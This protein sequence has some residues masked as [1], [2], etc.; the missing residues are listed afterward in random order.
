MTAEPQVAV[1]A[2]AARDD[3]VL[4]VR[5]GRSWSLPG[6]LVRMGEDLREAVV[7]EVLD[8][9][10]LEVVVVEFAGWWERIE[11]DAAPPVHVVALAFGVDQ[12]DAA[13]VPAPGTGVAELNWTPLASL[14]EVP[15]AA[16]VAELLTDRGLL[17]PD[18]G[19]ELHR[20]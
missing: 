13:Q 16:G 5:Q 8:A 18:P 19:I 4:L 10:G 15:L 11:P 1:A 14:A 20:P 9:T 6:G 2:V 17:V 12:L 3:E 7:R